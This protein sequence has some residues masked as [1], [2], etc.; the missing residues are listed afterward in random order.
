[1]RQ[2]QLLLCV[3]VTL[4]YISAA[5]QVTQTGRVLEYQERQQKTPLAQV[6]MSITNAGSTLSDEQG[7]FILQFRTLRPGDK[8][9]VRRIEKLGYEI[10][11]RDA[12]SQWYIARD[13]QPFT[14]VM[15][16]SDRF[17]R[18]RDNY[19][20]ISS[21]S[22]A[23]QAK[24]DEQQLEKLRKAKKIQEDEYQERLRALRDDMEQRLEDLDSYIDRFARIDLTELSDVEARIIALVQQGEIDKA[25]KLYEAQHLEKQ[26]C[27][28]SKQLQTLRTA[29]DTLTIIAQQKAQSRDELFASLQR[30]NDMLVL[31]GGEENFKKIR[32]S[33]TQ[34]VDADTTY[35]PAIT[36]LAQFLYKQR[37]YVTARRYYIM[38]ISQCS[39]AHLRS[40]LLMNLGG[41]CVEANLFDEALRAYEQAHALAQAQEPRQTETV[42]AILR[43]MGYALLEEKQYEAAESRLQESRLLLMNDSANIETTTWLHE[44]AKTEQLLGELYKARNQFNQALE[45][46]I[47]AYGCM[48]Q[49]IQIQPQT[50]RSDYITTVQQVGN[51]YCL[52]KQFSK[53]EPYLLEALTFQREQYAVNP[54]AYR[55]LLASALVNIGKLYY[56]QGDNEKAEP[57]NL[58]AYTLTKQ[59][60]EQQQ[61]DVYRPLLSTLCLNLGINYQDLKQY[62]QAEQFL[63]EGIAIDKLLV[64]KARD[65]YLQNLSAM[66]NML[67]LNYK[68]TEQYEKALSCMLEAKEYHEELMALQPDVHKPQMVINLQDLG[69]LYYTMGQYDEGCN[70]FKQSTTLL[71]ELYHDYPDVY[72]MMMTQSL[73]NMSYSHSMVGR[74]EL[75]DEYARECLQ[76]LH[77]EDRYYTMMKGAALAGLAQSAYMRN[78]YKAALDWMEQALDYDPKNLIYIDSKGAALLKLGRKDEARKVRQQILDADPDFFKKYPTAEMANEIIDD[79]KQ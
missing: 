10:F 37:D 26:F 76:I 1:M 19:E 16:R 23:R 70:Q 17:K 15:C 73:I 55:G 27:K 18:I 12:I 60:M 36:A 34:S 43:G 56:D 72:Y 48:K 58:E 8:V 71:R 68:M 31:A 38:A 44:R 75:A 39:E 61:P 42:A 20:R 29:I 2:H 22:Y 24:H 77:P 21:E 11:N 3:L 74:Y 14:V 66:L 4:C 45:K 54:E 50:Y 52:L 28:E 53:A 25:V 13:G 30:K 69:S 64:E 35:L 7:N 59:L 41:A 78:D 5:A 46:S 33:L 40:Q 65:I 51:L 57:Y 63:M 67:G 6:E 49:L 9:S 32:E 62:E 79:N 47:T